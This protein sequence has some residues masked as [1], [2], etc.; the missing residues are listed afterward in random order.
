[1]G[2][3][4]FVHSAAMADSGVMNLEETEGIVWEGS[5]ANVIRVVLYNYGHF[6]KVMMETLPW[7]LQ[8]TLMRIWDKVS[9]LQSFYIG[10][11]ISHYT[12][13][14]CTPAKQGTPT[15]AII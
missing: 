3:A 5:L 7:L 15:S 10:P 2:T 9:N 8:L 1:M 13:I 11:A 14:A 12:S 6:Y 4:R